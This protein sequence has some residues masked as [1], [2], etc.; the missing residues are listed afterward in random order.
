VPVRARTTPPL[1][2]SLQLRRITQHQRRH[3]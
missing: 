3:I 2:K 1:T